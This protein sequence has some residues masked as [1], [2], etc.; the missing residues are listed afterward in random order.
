MATLKGAEAVEERTVAMGREE[1][2]P[3]RPLPNPL[4]PVH[5][6]GPG[7]ALTAVR[8]ICVGAV[9]VLLFLVFARLLR[10][11]EVNDVLATFTGRARAR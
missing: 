1:P 2:L 5:L 11:T 9:D 6:L 8:L 4:K 7:M 3:I 10:I